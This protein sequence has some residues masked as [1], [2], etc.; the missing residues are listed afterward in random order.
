MADAIL[1]TKESKM[2]EEVSGLDA[3]DE[4]SLLRVKGKDSDRVFEI[5]YAYAKIVKHFRQLIADDVSGVLPDTVVP[6]ECLSDVLD[7]V[8]WYVMHQKGVESEEPPKPADLEEEKNVKDK[9]VREMLEK[10]WTENKFHFYELIRTCNYLR[11]DCLMNLAAALFAGKIK[12]YGGK[13]IEK[14]KE[15][16]TGGVP[17]W[18]KSAVVAPATSSVP[19]DAQPAEATVAMTD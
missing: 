18:A 10:L 9:D 3:V 13:D 6:L 2:E 14:V 12:K 16:I 8:H 1:E 4:K 19:A 11:L 15:V 7:R 17:D 5:P